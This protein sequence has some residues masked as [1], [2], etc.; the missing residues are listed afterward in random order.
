MRLVDL[1]TVTEVVRGTSARRDKVALL[2]DALRALAPDE[3]RAGASFLCGDLLQRQTGIGWAAIQAL[4]PPA[5]EAAL[6]IGEVDRAF[7]EAARLEGLGSTTRRQAIVAD[8]FG[9]ATAAEQALLRGLVGGEL[10]QGAQEGVLL[11]AIARATEIPLAAVRRAAMLLGD[12]PALA[13]LALVDGRA[14]VEAVRLAVGRPVLPM[15]AGTAVDVRSAVERLGAC[16]IEWKLDGARIQAHRDGSDVALFSRSLDDVTGR[17]PEIAAAILALPVDR[18]ILDGEAIALTA[19]GR[20][21]PFQETA[22]RFARDTSGGLVCML[23]D[24]LHLDGEDLLDRPGS[25]RR[26]LLEEAAGRLAVPGQHVTSTDEAE[27]FA[28]DALARGHEGVMLKALDATYEAGRRG[29]GWLKVKPVHTLDL[30]VLAAEWGHG[31]R[32]GLLSNLH[33]GAREPATGAFVMLGKTFKGLTD[34]LLAWQTEALLARAIERDDWRVV[35]RPE[36]V[37]E[38][39]FDGVQRST[40]YPGGVTLRF[41][42]VKRYRPD[43]LSRDADTIDTVRARLG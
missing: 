2:A 34:E 13:R 9:R 7:A 12:V 32:R 25:A 35:V 26:V 27:V 28:A 11:D 41:A 30:V 18:A 15:L 5:A 21:R 4:P 24:V 8:L 3:A 19:D 31:R 22:S 6:T 37:V 16:A 40:R 17:L 39:A 1:A 23:F 20:P 33:L 42:R 43:K 29:S 14:A 36:L 38:I 10:R